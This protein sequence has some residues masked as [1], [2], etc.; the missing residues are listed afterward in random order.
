MK[1]LSAITKYLSPDTQSTN[2]IAHVIN[3][4]KTEPDN[5]SYLFYA[6]PITFNSM[7]LAQQEA[8]KKNIHVDLYSVNYPEDDEIIENG[9]EKLPHLIRST[10]SSYPELTNRKLPFLDDILNTLKNNSTADYFVFTNTD[11]LVNRT[12][13]T[14]VSEYIESGH[15]AFVINRRD[16]IPKFIDGKRLSVDDLEL[17]YSLPGEIHGGFDCFIF[18]RQLLERINIEDMFIGFPPWGNLL[19]QELY[20]N[21]KQFSIFTDWHETFHIGN[22]R[23][24]DGAQKHALWKQNI[25][26][27][28][29]IGYNYKL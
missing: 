20:K 17:I 27:A 6:Q 13:Y 21:A 1:L 14:K 5:A 4:F 24:W 3:P 22:D 10:A 28:H 25:L 2:S 23:S 26:N 11:I 12:F 9:F 15:E 29:K 8:I 16:N 18:H 7:L 19:K